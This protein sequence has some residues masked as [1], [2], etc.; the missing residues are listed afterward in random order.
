MATSEEKRVLPAG[1]IG[2][3]HCAALLF[4]QVP[5]KLID[6]AC[7]DLDLSLLYIWT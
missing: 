4:S 6:V 3:W 1:K 2:I 7:M 5:N